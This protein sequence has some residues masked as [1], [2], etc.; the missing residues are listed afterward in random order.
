MSHDLQHIYCWIFQTVFNLL[1][2]NWPHFCVRSEILVPFIPSSALDFQQQH[3][4][5][6]P[7]T[8]SISS[9]PKQVINPPAKDSWGWG[10]DVG[11]WFHPFP[12]PV[13]GW[14]SKAPWLQPRETKATESCGTN[15]LLL[16]LR[17]WFQS[18]LID[19][20]L[21]YSPK[22]KLELFQKNTGKSVICRRARP[23]WLSPLIFF[24]SFQ[25]CIATQSKSF[26][27]RAWWPST[28]GWVSQPCT[29]GTDWWPLNKTCHWYLFDPYHNI[30]QHC[31]A[32]SSM[33]EAHLSLAEWHF[34]LLL[35]P[36][37]LPH[38]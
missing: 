8:W 33:A 10:G 27:S 30:R 29:A 7:G 28:R 14:C 12:I 13:A 24:Q 23:W 20:K 4:L 31:L 18:D 9:A 36:S 37:L 32:W 35:L 17:G 2:H 34:A 38:L 15:L 26:D 19:F 11:G 16:P 21:Q 1:L 25:P 22:D 5:W 3:P 6:S